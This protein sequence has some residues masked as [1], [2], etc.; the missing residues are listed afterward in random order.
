MYRNVLLLKI[1]IKWLPLDDHNCNTKF[2]WININWYNKYY[3]ELA[4][5]YNLNIFSPQI[6]VKRS[7]LGTCLVFMKIMKKCMFFNVNIY[8]FNI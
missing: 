8:V 6:S 3:S 2:Y 1:F 7:C 5:K 4:Y